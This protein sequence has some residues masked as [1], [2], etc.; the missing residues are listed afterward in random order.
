MKTYFIQLI[1]D[2]YESISSLLV[3]DYVDSLNKGA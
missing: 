3:K 2:V 1:H